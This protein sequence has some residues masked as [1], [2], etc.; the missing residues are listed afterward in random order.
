MS[1]VV[2]SHHALTV[3]AG[4]VE[5]WTV[6]C[7]D[8]GETVTEDGRAVYAHLKEAESARDL[9]NA[10]AH[11]AEPTEASSDAADRAFLKEL[12]VSL[13][14]IPVAPWT[15]AALLAAHRRTA[16]APGETA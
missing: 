16:N 1:A 12:A 5:F 8:C 6:E 10:K 7:C 14:G 4:V 11:G 15:V 13:R 9:H 2:A 3:R